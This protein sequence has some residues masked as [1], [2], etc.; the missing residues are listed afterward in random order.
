MRG[1]VRLDETAD[2]AVE[3]DQDSPFATAHRDQ[4]GISGFRGSGG[5]LGHI[6]PLTS[7]PCDDRAIDV[8]IGE[9]LYR[10]AAE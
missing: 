9:N 2:V 5:S 3:G 8:F 4:I 10:Q 1:G 7:K 6:M